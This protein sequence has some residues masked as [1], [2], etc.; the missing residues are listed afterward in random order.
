MSRS[1]GAP[2]PAHCGEVQ[3]G[4]QSTHALSLQRRSALESPFQG[5]VLFIHLSGLPQGPPVLLPR[6]CRSDLR[7][8]DQCWR[9]VWQ[10]LRQ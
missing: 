3:R 2:P 5:T 6:G 8:A 4:W 1:R 10:E 7:L 9:W